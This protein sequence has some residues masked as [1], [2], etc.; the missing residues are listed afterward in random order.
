MLDVAEQIRELLDDPKQ[1][2]ENGNAP[3][4]SALTS[5]LDNHRPIELYYGNNETAH[6]CGAC[7]FFT[8]EWPC[9]T[10]RDMAEA[11]GLEAEDG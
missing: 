6:I 1:Y 3:L 2:D 11:L 5:V 10:V 4:I 9:P 7:R 8:S